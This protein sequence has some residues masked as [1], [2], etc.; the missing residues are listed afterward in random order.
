MQVL[1]TPLRAFLFCFEFI[2]G[3]GS[4]VKSWLT[5]MSDPMA[6]IYGKGLALSSLPYL[7]LTLSS[8]D[9]IFPLTINFAFFSVKP[10]GPTGPVGFS[11]C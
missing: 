11:P 2:F 7:P 3:N 1:F 8:P 9:P 6:Q 5:L 10:T 4:L